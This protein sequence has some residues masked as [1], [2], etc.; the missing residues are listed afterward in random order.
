MSIPEVIALATEEVDG[1]AEETPFCSAR[2]ADFITVIRA[3][4][5]RVVVGGNDDDGPADVPADGSVD[6][7][8]GIGVGET[9]KGASG[10]SS[11]GSGGTDEERVRLFFGADMAETVL[12]R[13]R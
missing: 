7:G 3:S 12:E 6:G 4:M 8:V 9:L 13:V 2:T 5:V 1:P 10:P 11:A